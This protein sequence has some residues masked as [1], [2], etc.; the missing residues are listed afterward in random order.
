MNGTSRWPSGR[1]LLPGIALAF[2]LS[3]AV[4]AALI[5]FQTMWVTAAVLVAL[6]AISGVM[7]LVVVK[8]I[9]ADGGEGH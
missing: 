9:G 5:F 4:M 7:V 2:A 6:V 8:L 3:L 1:G